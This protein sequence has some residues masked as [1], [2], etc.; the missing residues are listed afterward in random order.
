LVGRFHG[1]AGLRLSG[2]AQRCRAAA[3]P[4]GN[5]RRALSDAG[6]RFGRAGSAGAVSGRITFASHTLVARYSLGEV[7]MFNRMLKLGVM[8]M[9]GAELSLPLAAPAHAV[10]GDEPQVASAA[11]PIVPATPAAATQPKP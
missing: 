2:G 3:Q 6:R 11:A 9:T 7:R 5:H 1:G 4:A 8:V 10:A